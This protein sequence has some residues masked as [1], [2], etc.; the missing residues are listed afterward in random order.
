MVASPVF[1]DQFYN[2]TLLRKKK[3]GQLVELK[4]ITPAKLISAFKTV[5][6]DPIYTAEARHIA[7][8]TRDLPIQPKKTFLRW[9]NYIHKHGAKQ[10]FTLKSVELSFV[11]LHSLDVIFVT[12][13]ALL[14]GIF[15]LSKVH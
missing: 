6:E 2:A 10:D 8:K 4:T 3:V 11:K 9:A 15:V 7:L 13:L 14:I 1:G 12:V 5:L